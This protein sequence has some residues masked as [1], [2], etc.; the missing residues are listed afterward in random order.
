MSLIKAWDVAYVRFRAPDPARM[1]DF[2]L[3]FGMAEAE[4][5]GSRVFMR[6]CGPQPF[7]HATETGSAGFAGFGFHV[8]SEAGLQ[9]LAA[10][11][12]RPVEPLDAPGGGQVVRLTDPDGFVVEAVY[13]QLPVAPLPTP[14][15][16]LWNQG[17]T[18]ARTGKERRV[19]KGPSHILRLGHVVLGVSDFRRSEAWY[20][21]RFGLITSD[22]IQP[23]PNVAIGAFLRCDRG[24]VP[25]DHHTLFLL[26]RPGPAG[27]M[28]AAFEVVDVDDLMAGREHLLEQHAEAV[29]GVGRHKLGSQVFDYW[30]DPWGHELEHWTDGDQFRA[31][32]GSRVATLPDLLGV[33]WGMPMPPHPDVPPQ[34]ARS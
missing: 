6:G 30:R 25:S 29:W 18:I 5:S 2:L 32:D 3:D 23:A 27:F 9:A 21:E 33:Q 4:V 19:P 7:L 15:P 1:H 10:A 16:A 17:G 12:A 11:E 14:E 34:G 8:T 24:E 28:H 13:G 26:Q 20:K 22:E 31:S